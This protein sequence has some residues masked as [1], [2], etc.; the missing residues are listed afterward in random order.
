M[1]IQVLVI[2]LISKG[3]LGQ[4]N[5]P[6]PWFFMYKIEII[7][8]TPRVAGKIKRTWEDGPK[9]LGMLPGTKKESNDTGQTIN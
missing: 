3:N 9:D 8:P 2:I 6:K 7:R 1:W 5:F 4:T